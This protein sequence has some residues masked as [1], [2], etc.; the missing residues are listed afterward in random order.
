M[1][2]DVF[3]LAE[4]EVRIDRHHRDAERIEREPQLDE[5]GPVLEQQ[6]DPVAFAVA[7]ARKRYAT[8]LDPVEHRAVGN[9]ARRNAVDACGLRQH[10]E[11]ARLAT[12]ERGLLKTGMDSGRRG[13]GSLT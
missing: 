3:E 6:P 1:P 10:V 8:A 2:D 4:T 13:Q 7:A 11:E 9:L 5:D 12:A